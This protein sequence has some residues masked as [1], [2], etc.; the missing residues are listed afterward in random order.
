VAALC[1]LA[2]GAL[3]SWALPRRNV[4][5]GPVAA[6]GALFVGFVAYAALSG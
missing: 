5:K 3:A 2:G 4:G 1:G 6:W